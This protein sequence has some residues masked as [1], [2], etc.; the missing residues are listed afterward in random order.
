M[1]DENARGQGSEN[2]FVKRPIV[3]KQPQRSGLRVRHPQLPLHQVW[4][5]PPIARTAACQPMARV[6]I[7]FVT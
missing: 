7:A 1:M 6:A 4:A 5:T 3:A 2:K